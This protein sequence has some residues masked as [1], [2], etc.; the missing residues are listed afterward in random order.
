[1][2]VLVVEDDLAI[3]GLIGRGLRAMGH[4]VLLAGNGRDAIRECQNRGFDAVVLD[5]VL[6]DVCGLV[7]LERLRAMGK[8]PKVLMLSALGSVQERIDGLVAGADDY[9]TKPFDLGELGARLAAITRRGTL[10][11]E[12]ET[13]ELV[14]GRL[15]LDPAG[16]RALMD[17]G[18]VS[19]N[20]REYS[21]LAF[22][23]RHAD[24]VVTRSMLLQGVWDYGFE[25]RT[26][27]V[28]S[29]LSR[30]RTRLVLLGCDPVETRR[31]QGYVLRS[32]RCA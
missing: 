2:D 8:T 1:M 24:H 27:I 3:A 23:M 9:L 7:V 6:P 4:H 32:D 10:N 5:R 19:L 15:R 25:P 22:L 11:E 18:S 31:G 16:H 28:E 14:V 17:A 29:N 21:L 30:L 26:N 20:K 12:P 13:P